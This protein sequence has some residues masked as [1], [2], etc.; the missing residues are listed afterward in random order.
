MKTRVL[1]Q[2]LNITDEAVY[3]LPGKCIKLLSVQE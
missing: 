2:I 3:N 1:K